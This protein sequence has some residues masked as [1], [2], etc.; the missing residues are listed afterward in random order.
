MLLDVWERALDGIGQT[1][2]VHGEPG[3]GKSRLVFA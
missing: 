1:M 3:V 2:L